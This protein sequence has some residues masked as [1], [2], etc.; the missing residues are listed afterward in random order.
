[1]FRSGVLKE[2]IEEL[3]K[4]LLLFL[5][6][7]GY[8]KVENYFTDGTILSADANRHKVV[9]R[10]NAQR[11]KQIAEANCQKLFKEID[12]LNAEENIE[13]GEGDLEELGS[14]PIES[15]S[16]ESQ[17]QRLNQVIAKTEK[18]RVA[19][20]AKSLKRQLEEQKEKINQYDQQLLISEQRSGYSKTDTEATAMRLKNSDDLV[21]AYNV[22][23][24]CENQFITAISVHQNPN[25][26][27][28]FK[29]HFEQLPLKPST[30]TAD[31]IFG[32]EQNYELLEGS[33][34]KSFLKFPT[35]DQQTTSHHKRN[36]KVLR[37]HFIYNRE[38]DTYKCPDGRELGYKRTEIVKH[39]KTGYQSTVKTYQSK[40]CKQCAL[41]SHCK[42]SLESNR[43]L[44]VNT[45]LDY[46]RQQARNN[47][48]S[49]QGL[50]L[51]RRRG[52][53][54][55]SCFGDIKH[56]MEF[57]RFHLRGKRKVKTEIGLISMAHNLRKIQIHLKLVA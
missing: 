9:W 10:K 37:E 19:I 18:K 28:C 2:T 55:E 4:Q 34:I 7:H 51:R 36:T 40:N 16:I 13:Y 46:Y 43:T 17:V 53:E 56:N 23:A 35:F 29:E 3:F 1:L 12:T 42:T 39:K 52:A 25:D 47:L 38:K 22:M 50:D 45:Q 41:A 33:Q 44:T 26:A 54:I 15:Q 20:K 30:I 48:N 5:V 31:S 32:T 11:Y 8:I 6:D 27:T 24:S 14:E 49:S 57:R 21:P